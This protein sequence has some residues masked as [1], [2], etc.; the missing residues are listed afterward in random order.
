[1]LTHFFARTSNNIDAVVYACTSVCVC[2]ERQH[3]HFEFPS[4]IAFWFWYMQSTILHSHN[5]FALIQHLVWLCCMNC[6]TFPQ[7]FTIARISFEKKKKKTKKK[8]NWKRY[9]WKK[10]ER[11]KWS[12]TT[13]MTA[14][15]MCKWKNRNLFQPLVT[16]SFLQS[17][18]SPKSSSVWMRKRVWN[19]QRGRFRKRNI[20]I[21]RKRL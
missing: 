20:H 11:R 18:Y 15:T 16:F 5:S 9:I 13:Q 14:A 3:F 2:R 4:F 8:M 6:E 10:I 7:E 12:N 21:L 1:M 19:W 17:T